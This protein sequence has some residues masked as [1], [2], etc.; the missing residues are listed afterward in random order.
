MRA[1]LFGSI[2]TLIETSDIQ[3]ESFNQAFKENGLDWYWSKETYK[4]LLKNSG[5]SKRIEN[6]AK[7]NN[8]DVDSKF[9]RQ[10]KTEIF[11]N[12][13]KSRN[14]HPREGVLEII[15][16]AKSHNIKI[17]LASSTTVE[18]IEAVFITLNNVITKSDFDFIGNDTL[19]EKHKPDPDIYFKA[20][21]SLGI[22][23]SECIAIEDSVESS[24]SAIKAKIDCVAFPGVF[25]ID[26]N[27]D[28]CKKYLKKLDISIFN[29]N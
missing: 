20:I 18:N 19:I 5:G 12:I 9:L 16:Y 4:N 26:D 29:N 3:R 1:I 13:L 28:I 15:K 10:R 6:F 7:K 14:T 23:S 21:E 11:N 8:I 27:F 24:I 17:G 22:N 2:G 25:H